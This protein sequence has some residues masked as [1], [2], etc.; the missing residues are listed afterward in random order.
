MVVQTPLPQLLAKHGFCPLAVFRLLKIGFKGA[1]N[2]PS[3][4]RNSRNIYVPFPV[5]MNRK[6]YG[7]L[8]AAGV[9]V[10]ILLKGRV[11]IPVEGQPFA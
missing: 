7:E 3:V 6:G 4:L 10:Q 9:A 2:L 8:S 11:D 5:D 1:E